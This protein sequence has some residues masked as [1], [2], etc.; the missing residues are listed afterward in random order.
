MLSKLVVRVLKDD[1][2]G[3]INPGRTFSYEPDTQKKSS[4]LLITNIVLLLAQSIGFYN[5]RKYYKKD[6]RF[7]SLHAYYDVVR[8]LQRVRV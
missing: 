1:W 2:E 7:R 3:T 5:M 8:S 6:A 4:Q